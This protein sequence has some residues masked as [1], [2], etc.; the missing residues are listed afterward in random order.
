MP[1]R[2]PSSR[3]NAIAEPV[4]YFFAA[5]VDISQA[6]IQATPDGLPEDAPRWVQIATEGDYPG[7]RN[8]EQPFSLTRATFQQV[9]D[10]LHANPS[11]R[12]GPDGV[13]EANVVPWDF[14]HASELYPADGSIPTVGAPAQAWTCELEIRDSAEGK[15]ELWGLTR[16]LDLARGY[17]RAGQY[18]WASVSITF[19]TIDPASARNVGAVLTSVAMTNNPIVRGMQKL[20]ASSGAAQVDASYYWMDPAEDSE[21]ALEKIKDLLGL[22]KT[23]DLGS[24]TG[25]L[26]KLRQW[27]T[28][29]MAPVGV[30]V[31]DLLGAMRRLF[32]LPALS[33]IDDVLAEAD[34]MIAGLVQ[35]QAGQPAASAAAT[36]AMALERTDDMELLKILASQLGVR[37]SDDAVKTAV[38]TLATLQGSMKSLLGTDSDAPKVLLDAAEKAVGARLKLTALLKALG[39]ENADAAVEQVATLMS[40]AKELAKV[41]PELKSLQARVKEMDDAQASADVDAV[42]ASRQWDP[43]LKD[44]LLLSYQADPAKFRE[45]YPLPDKGNEHLLSSVVVN[46]P[47]PQPNIQPTPR[48]TQTLLAD[49]AVV[50]LSIY[51]GSNPTEKAMEYLKATIPG[52][53]KWTH[54]KLWVSACELKKQPNVVIQ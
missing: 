19:N 14:H 17:I 22:P 39:V 33:T 6:L 54:D 23:A 51:P 48:P 26:A 53:S 38:A 8:G 12:A 37:E 34:K 24:L 5:G 52:A 25:E 45:K 47:K 32:N 7:Y 29:G 9:I 18:Q 27:S 10:N 30:D 36:A 50:N 42:I 43:S 41:M 15:A 16:F 49:Q 2:K 11:Y 20:V 40:Q 21:E 28:P 46:P 3:K 1:R 31:D 44:A 13:G 4:R 35:G